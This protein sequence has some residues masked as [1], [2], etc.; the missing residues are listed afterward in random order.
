MRIRSLGK[1]QRGVGAVEFALI[2]PVLFMMIIG[3]AQMGILFLA[4]AGLKHAVAEGARF[5]ALHPR[6]TAANVRTRI[7]Q[8]KLSLK[9]EHLG[10]VTI[11]SGSANGSD[12]LD[13]TMTYSVPLNFVFVSVAPIQLR[14]QRRVFIYPAAA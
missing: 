5:A 11:V 9:A 1:D 3:I 14:E 12:F 6:P 8:K 2:A 7:L 13:V 4:N 10:P